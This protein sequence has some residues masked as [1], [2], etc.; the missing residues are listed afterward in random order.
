MLTRSEFNTALT[1]KNL[2]LKELNVPL[3]QAERA[4]ERGMKTKTKTTIR[5]RARPEV[6]A[7]IRAA[8]Q[9]RGCTITAL[10]ELAVM[11]TPIPKKSN[12]KAAAKRL[13]G[14][15]ERISFVPSKPVLKRLKSV[16]L[17]HGSRSHWLESWG[18]LLLEETPQQAFHR[19]SAAA[20]V[21]AGH[22]IAG[23]GVDVPYRGQLAVEFQTNSGTVI[24]CPDGSVVVPLFAHAEIF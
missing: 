19:L 5:I 8:A 24:V 14:A 11:T 4:R 13:M 16:V 10:I 12:Q 17:P 7:A 3:S 20:A 2:V 23:Q 9:E 22:A 6:A 21:Q 1:W 18:A 15:T